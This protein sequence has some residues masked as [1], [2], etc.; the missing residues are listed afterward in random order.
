MRIGW[1]QRRYHDSGLSWPAT[2]C[3]NA[4]VHP[5]TRPALPP[6]PPRT[7][8]KRST[9]KMALEGQ[10]QG[11]EIIL[12]ESRRTPPRDW[13]CRKLRLGERGFQVTLPRLRLLLA[14]RPGLRGTWKRPGGACFGSTHAQR[15][16][17]NYSR[18]ARGAR[19]SAGRHRPDTTKT[20]GRSRPALR[21]LAP[22]L[23]PHH[24]P[25]TTQRAIWQ[26]RPALALGKL[27]Q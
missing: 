24:R 27:P 9:G 26:S 19:G 20:T 7:A 12:R 17:F 23:Q 21:R 1:Q 25:A 15:I 3:G 11:G 22:R 4:A 5:C 6:T 13:R 10:I 2:V 16:R 14:G 18:P 8:N